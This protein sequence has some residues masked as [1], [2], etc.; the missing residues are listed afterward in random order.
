MAMYARHLCE[1]I[2]YDSLVIL[3]SAGDYVKT[4]ASEMQGERGINTILI[5]GFWEDLR[6][7]IE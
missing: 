5:K 2:D 4:I 1:T 6:L 7:E 3:V